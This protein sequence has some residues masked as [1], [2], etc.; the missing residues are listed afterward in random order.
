MLDQSVDYNI[1]AFFASMDMDPDGGKFTFMVG[2]F[3]LSKSLNVPTWVK[4]QTILFLEKVLQAT[5]ALLK[6]CLKQTLPWPQT[7]QIISTEKKIVRWT[8]SVQ[9]KLILR[10]MWDSGKPAYTAPMSQ[11]N[12]DNVKN[13]RVNFLSDLVQENDLRKFNSRLFN[14]EKDD[15]LMDFNRELNS[16]KDVKGKQSYEFEPET[17]VI[18]SDSS[19]ESSPEQLAA[20]ETGIEREYP[21]EEAM[22]N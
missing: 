3:D 9:V 12:I 19:D 22:A 4:P 7:N 18:S 11:K 16:L 6:G 10:D 2:D 14:D 15:K 17:I 21:S 20:K 13:E 1:K 8:E 5:P